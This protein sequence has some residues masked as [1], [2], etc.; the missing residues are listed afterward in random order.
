MAPLPDNVPSFRA[1][2]DKIIAF[3]QALFKPKSPRPRMHTVPEGT[4]STELNEFGFV[5]V[6]G[7]P[8]PNTPEPDRLVPDRPGARWPSFNP[9]LETIYEQSE[10]GSSMLNLKGKRSGIILPP[11]CCGFDS[12]TTKLTH[13]TVEAK[14]PLAIAMQRAGTD[15]H[16]RHHRLVGEAHITYRQEIPPAISIVLV[17]AFII[18]AGM[19]VT[20]IIKRRKQRRSNP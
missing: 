13:N 12:F 9:E 3:F 5:P 20:F 19:F 7:F 6:P 2:W 17:I 4:E 15:S 8:R 18:A 11:S 16:V 14:E 1:L 10:P